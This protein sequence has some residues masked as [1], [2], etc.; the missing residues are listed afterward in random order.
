MIVSADGSVTA[1]N[2]RSGPLGGP[3]DRE[4]FRALRATA[5][6]VLAGASTVRT[7]GYGLP[8]LPQSAQ[9]HRVDAGKPSLPRLATVSAS[10][11][12]DIGARFF[13]EPAPDQRPLVLTTE[14]SL[15]EHPQRA[16]DLSERVALVVAGQRIVDWHAALGALHEEAGANIVLVEG[17]PNVNGQLMVEDLLDELC[18]TIAP[19]LVSG[20]GD[21]LA[22]GASLDPPGELSLARIAEQDG[23]L[24][25]RYLRQR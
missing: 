12:F 20:R 11:R 14:A 21:R 15:K 3:P 1:A 6:V 19:T 13:R 2:G 7:E 24:M 8:R 16:A 25:L 22:L 23:F 4:M 9:Q 18:V 10:L 17:G 5:D